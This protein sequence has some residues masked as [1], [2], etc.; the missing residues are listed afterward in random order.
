MFLRLIH[1]DQRNHPLAAIQAVRISNDLFGS[2]ILSSFEM[3]KGYCKPIL[4]GASPI[5]FVQEIFDAQLQLDAKRK[6]T[7]ILRSR[8]L[9]KSQ[10]K[11]GDLVEV[12]V[13]TGKEKRGE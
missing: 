1:D 3:T 12:F 7:R 5:P 4:P 9:Q 13:K 8:S 11:V 6:L 10:V 2:D